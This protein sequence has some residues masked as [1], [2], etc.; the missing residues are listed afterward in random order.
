M[1]EFTIGCYGPNADNSVVTLAQCLAVYSGCS[2]TA[3]TYNVQTGTT[4]R[5]P[6]TLTAA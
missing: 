2:S 1:N 4:S 6:K 5:W 3:M